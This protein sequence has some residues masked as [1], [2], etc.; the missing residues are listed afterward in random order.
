MM[1][2]SSYPYV[3]ELGELSWLTKDESKYRDVKPKLPSWA[4][5]HLAVVVHVTNDEK[6]KNRHVWLLLVSSADIMHIHS[7]S[8][9]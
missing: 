6:V 7:L 4:S 2:V 5:G 1:A 3:P 8:L 9:G